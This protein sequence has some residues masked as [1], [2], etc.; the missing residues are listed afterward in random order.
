MGLD[1]CFERL[2]EPMCQG[3]EGPPGS[4]RGVGGPGREGRGMVRDEGGLAAAGRWHGE[5]LV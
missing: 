5:E 2:P 4:K 1:F 3:L